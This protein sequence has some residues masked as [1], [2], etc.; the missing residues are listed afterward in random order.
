M[1]LVILPTVSWKSSLH[2]GSLTPQLG[3]RPI[4]VGL[5]LP[6]IIDE[7]RPLNIWLLWD[8]PNNGKVL[9]HSLLFGLMTLVVKIYLYLS[10]RRLDPLWSSFGSLSQPNLDEMWLYLTTMPWPLCGWNFLKADVSH[11]SGKLLTS[12]GTSPMHV[13]LTSDVIGV[14]LVGTFPFG[15]VRHP[16]S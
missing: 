15:L 5:R 10:R 12:P 1:F 11:W 2:L 8:T 7:R 6:D 4:I 14:F 13:L 9:G 3:S 16:R